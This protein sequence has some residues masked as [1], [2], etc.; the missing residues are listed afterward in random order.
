[1]CGQAIKGACLLVPAPQTSS[2]CPSKKQGTWAEA[3]PIIGLR[4]LQFVSVI[5]TEKR[6]ATLCV[7]GVRYVCFLHLCTF[8]THKQ[9]LCMRVLENLVLVLEPL[10]GGLRVFF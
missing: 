10:S 8:L 9:G 3:Q 7:F 1:M 4:R 5:C 6:V 2:A